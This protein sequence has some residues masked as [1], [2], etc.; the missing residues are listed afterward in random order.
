M[1]GNLYSVRVILSTHPSTMG[2]NPKPL[3]H[4]EVWDDTALQKSWD[5]ALAEYKVRSI[6]LVQSL[7]TNFSNSF[8]I[9]YTL[10]GNAWRMF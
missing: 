1:H 5:D 6:A 3:S 8:I 2:K 4:D 10:E 7:F 9:A